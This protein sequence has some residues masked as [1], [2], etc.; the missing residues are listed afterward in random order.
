MTRLCYFALFAPKQ[1]DFSSY[2]GVHKSRKR[3]IFIL[4]KEMELIARS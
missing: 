3:K 1:S 2:S 4:L